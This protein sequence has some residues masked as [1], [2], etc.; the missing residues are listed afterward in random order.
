MTDGLNS[1][2]LAGVEVSLIILDAGI[3]FD[4]SIQA[5]HDALP[6]GR[7]SRRSVVYPTLQHKTESPLQQCYAQADVPSECTLKANDYLECL[8]KPKEVRWSHVP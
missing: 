7:S 6:T 5:D 1:L 3:T 8:H 4:I 2:D